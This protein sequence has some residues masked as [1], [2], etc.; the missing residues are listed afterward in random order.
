MAEDD[1]DG[2]WREQCVS[3]KFYDCH[4]EAVRESYDGHQSYRTGMHRQEYVCDDEA[5][6]FDVGCRKAWF[7]KDKHV[8]GSGLHPRTDNGWH[9]NRVSLGDSLKNNVHLTSDSGSNR[10]FSLNTSQ[11]GPLERSGAHNFN[12]RVHKHGCNRKSSHSDD[13]LHDYGKSQRGIIRGQ[14][15][16]HHFGNGTQHHDDRHKGASRNGDMEI[17]HS[18]YKRWKVQSNHGSKHAKNGSFAYNQGMRGRRGHHFL[19][20]YHR[21][22]HKISNCDIVRCTNSNNNS[23][24][25]SAN[26]D[27]VCRSHMDH[28]SDRRSFREEAPPKII[29]G[30]GSVEGAASNHTSCTTASPICQQVEAQ[31]ND[32]AAQKDVP[33][34]CDQMIPKRAFISCNGGT[35]KRRRSCGVRDFPERSRKVQALVM[36]KTIIKAKIRKSFV[37]KGSVSASSVT[38]MR[39]SNVQGDPEELPETTGRLSSPIDAGAATPDCD[40]AGPDSIAYEHEASCL[41]IDGD[42]SGLLNFDCK[43][44]I[45]STMNIVHCEGQLCAESTRNFSKSNSYS[46]FISSFPEEDYANKGL[47]PL[48]PKENNRS[49]GLVSLDEIKFLEIGTSDCCVEPVR[50]DH[51]PI[52]EVANKSVLEQG[53]PSAELAIVNPDTDIAMSLVT[54]GNEQVATLKDVNCAQIA[55]GAILPRELDAA[56]DSSKSN[57]SSAPRGYGF[58]NKDNALKNRKYLTKDIGKGVSINHHA[59]KKLQQ[60]DHIEPIKKMQAFV[61]SHEGDIEYSS[62]KMQ[63]ESQA[64]ERLQEQEP[65]E[66]TEE[67]GAL[68]L[69]QD[70]IKDDLNKKDFEKR[71]HY[72]R[73]MS[74]K[75]KPEDG[76][77]TMKDM[78]APVL[79]QNTN[80][81]N[82]E[83]NDSKKRLHKGNSRAKLFQNSKSLDPGDVLTLSGLQTSEGLSDRTLVKRT[84][85]EFECIRKALVKSQNAVKR[86]DLEASTLLRE[87]GK[88][89]NCGDKIIGDVPGVEVGDQFSFRMEMLIIGLHR[90]VQSGIDYIPGTKR[91]NGS[92]LATSIVASGGYEDDKDDGNTLIY[93]GQGGNNSRGSKK[94]ESNQV[95]RFINL[96]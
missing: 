73:H 70:P 30:D 50:T 55:S 96:H 47:V 36:K 89:R 19:G 80:G 88:W 26:V 61:L 75:L 16:G 51:E 86:A 72:R 48:I 43:S 1:E 38:I 41:Q 35:R 31:D 68:I 23:A 10:H 79:F 54:A 25:D 42:I 93:S 37:P 4:S 24:Y 32:I 20:N 76:F 69:Y 53:N 29:K 84:L 39:G 57:K 78:E 46:C 45:E 49:G 13:H 14:G 91:S 63:I 56:N 27:L 44:S 90:Q 5:F 7:N 67:T 87:K 33:L 83:K 11:S 52:T 95:F 22:K 85:H 2:Y 6:T 71:L 34:L 8:E 92:P 12:Y 15:R 3:S 60:Q 82:M 28:K 64:L 65:F 18:N 81:R 94:Q 66:L 17:E 77:E 9:L 40:F 58:E 59:S 21:V 62:G 74:R